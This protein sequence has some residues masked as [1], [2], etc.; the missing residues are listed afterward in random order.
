MSDNKSIDY[1]HIVSGEERKQKERQINES[2]FQ[3]LRDSIGFHI[4]KTN[5]LLLEIHYDLKV[6]NRYLFILVLV[7]AIM[8][9]I[10]WLMNTV[11]R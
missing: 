5:D 4:G 7:I 6:S 9:L 11:F 3:E 8:P 1:S 2:D 10:D